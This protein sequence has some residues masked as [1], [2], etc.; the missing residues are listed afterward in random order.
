MSVNC[1]YLCADGRK[2]GNF[3]LF[4]P[5]DL[6]GGVVTTEI[7][8]GFHVQ[9]HLGIPF[10]KFCKFSGRVAFYLVGVNLIVA[11]SHRA[12]KDEGHILQFVAVLCGYTVFPPN[13]CLRID[14][15]LAYTLLVSQAIP[16]HIFRA[17][18]IACQG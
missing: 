9:Q 18:E 16:A 15:L 5:S 8:S 2:T 14:S 12:R 13:P 1:L 10:D 6:C 7:Q 11:S 3:V 17:S 4:M